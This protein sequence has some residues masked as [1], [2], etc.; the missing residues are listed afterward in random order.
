MGAFMRLSW[1]YD[2]IMLKTQVKYAIIHI[3]VYRVYHKMALIIKKEFNNM[4]DEFDFLLKNNFCFQQLIVYSGTKLLDRT[5]NA[6]FKSNKKETVLGQ[7]L[8]CLQESHRKTCET[9]GWEYDADL[10]FELSKTLLKEKVSLYQE[11]I[12]S[13]I[14]SEAVGHSID[15]KSINIWIEKFIE[16]LSDKKYERLREY[17]KFKSS[18][19]KNDNYFTQR[20]YIEKFEQ[21]LSLDED[22]K[23][24]ICEL[25]IPNT[26]TFP[27]YETQYDDLLHL[28]DSFIEDDLPCV[29]KEKHINISDKISAL[30]IFGHQCMGKSTLVSKILYDNYTQKLSREKN[31]HVVNFNDRNFANKDLT[32]RNICDLLKLD[33]SLLNKSILIVD[34]LDESNISNA[35][36]SDVLENLINDLREYDCKLIITSRLKFFMPLNIYGMI[37]ITLQPF[38]IEQARQWLEIYKEYNSNCNVEN[39]IFKI[40]KLNTDIRNVILIPYVFYICIK[41][42]IQFESIT[43]TARLYDII[44]YNE[45]AAFQATEYNSKHRVTNSDWEKYKAMVAEM[46]RYV[47]LNSI[48]D[49]PIYTL[50]TKDVDELAEKHNINV[51]KIATEFFMYRKDGDYYV[52][53]HNSI[54][55]YFVARYIYDKIVT[56]HLSNDFDTFVN[57]TKGFFINKIIPYSITDTIIYFVKFDNCKRIDTVIKIFK[58]FLTNDFSKQLTYNADFFTAQHYTYNFFVNI[59]KLLFAFV[60]AKGKPFESFVFFEKLD[61][62]ELTSFIKYT[63]LGNLPLDCLKLCSF[64]YQELNNVN[65]SNIYFLGHVISN[66]SVKN[67]NFSNSNV[68]GGY[69]MDSDFSNSCFDNAN[70]KNTDFENSMLINSSFKNAKLNGANFTKCNLDYV[71]LRGAQLKKCKFNGASMKGAKIN[72]VQLKD[73]FDFDIDY[74]RECCIEVYLEDCLI[75]DKCLDDE[76]RKQRPVGYLMNQIRKEHKYSSVDF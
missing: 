63:N 75:P 71:D 41:H 38:S 60:A 31:I 65:L 33:I 50:S 16:E 72:S 23:L 8:Q 5:L 11:K 10:Y 66:T 54:P 70:C 49:N 43:E 21:P 34:G 9:L 15:Q 4:I 61:K 51:N 13:G 39:I 46:S 25:Y 36:I 12:L 44:F 48:N 29:L 47:F 26:Y 1:V 22:T 3:G 37:S 62:N 32:P 56:A 67:S 76:Y 27:E 59:L 30:I 58:T 28:I 18:L 7:A 14:F 40:E 6:L 68:S 19:S 35:V 74:I 73:L 20:M 42:N 17:I 57:E 53:M 52:F 24:P 64:R 55:D 69:F 2:D 45:H